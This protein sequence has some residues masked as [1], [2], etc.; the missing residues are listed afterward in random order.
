LVVRTGVAAKNSFLTR[1]LPFIER[2]GGRNVAEVARGLGIPY[3]T[4]LFR[5]KKLYERGITIH[6]SVDPNKL[7]LGRMLVSFRLSTKLEN[8]K[9]EFFSSLNEVSY[10]TY[11][12]RYQVEPRFVTE[13]SVP[14]DH[15]VEFRRMLSQLEEM[16]LIEDVQLFELSWRQNI[17][18]RA[19]YYDY[20]NNE[21]DVDWSSL[22]D[23]PFHQ[24]PSPS[25]PTEFDKVDLL[26]LKELQLDVR[27]SLK[28]IARKANVSHMDLFRHYRNHVLGRNLVQTFVLRWV[29]TK[30]AWSKHGIILANL[31]FLNTDARKVAPVVLRLPFLTSHALSVDGRLYICDLAIPINQLSSTLRYLTDANLPI[32]DDHVLHFLDW[33]FAM[34]YVLPYH[35]YTDEGWSFDATSAIGRIVQALRL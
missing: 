28:S 1:L 7:K 35:T 10:L 20:E 23:V 6:G 2:N 5:I 25:E 11:V 22:R 19:E 30:Q 26:I 34:G 4:A 27:Q 15:Y 24:F 16:G 21:W 3:Q 31:C 14:F 9:K 13:F 29:G 32:T 17:T 18:M 12:G 33:N 8:T